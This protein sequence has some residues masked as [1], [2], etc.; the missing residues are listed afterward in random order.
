M[1]ESAGCLKLELRSRTLP[2]PPP[3]ASA[4]PDHM[5]QPPAVII[6][7]VTCSGMPRQRDPVI[8]NAIDDQDADDWLSQYEAQIQQF[9]REEVSRQLSRVP[10]VPTSARTL[11]STLLKSIEEQ[12]SDILSPTYHSS[13]ISSPLTLRPP[14]DHRRCYQLSRILFDSPDPSTQQ[15]HR[16]QPRP[17]RHS[18]APST[19]P[20]RTP[21][22]RPICYFRH[23]PGHVARYC[24]S[25]DYNPTA[26]ILPSGGNAADAA[27]EMA[28]CM[29]VLQPF[30]SG[31]GGDC[32]ALYHNAQEKQVHCVDGSGSS[33]AGLTLE[34]VESRYLHQKQMYGLHVTVPGAAKAWHHIITHFGSTKACLTT[35]FSKFRNS[36]R[37]AAEGPRAIYEGFVAECMVEAVH[38]ASGVLSTKDLSDHRASSEPMQVEPVKTTY[39]GNVTVHTTP[40]PTHGALMLEALNILEGILRFNNLKMDAQ[41]SQFLFIA[42]NVAFNHCYHR[43]RQR[44]VAGSESCACG[45][46][47]KQNGTS[48]M[49]K[50]FRVPR[51]GGLVAKVL[52]C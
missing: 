42:D 21:D 38:S 49:D 6:P 24:R 33:P 3:P 28:A 18:S 45:V 29:H 8:F 15:L 35:A 46:D 31:L 4:K 26:D 34:L 30:S 25:R 50:K 14:C 5:T 23:L 40:L 20:W 39:H 9:V 16:P 22:N 27:V 41:L 47:E 19:N 37:I 43:L 12:V 32:F 36:T 11:T 48:R 1:T 2:P 44:H 10:Y 17:V 52:G 7:S 51:H 13:P